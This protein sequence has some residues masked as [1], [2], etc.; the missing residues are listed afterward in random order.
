M[1]SSSEHIT[2]HGIC[3]IDGKV[4]FPSRKQARSV[5]RRMIREM[6]VPRTDERGRPLRVYRACEPSSFHIGHKGSLSMPNLNDPRL[7]WVEG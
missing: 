3:G 7:R 5:L 1:G 4:L 6:G 2:H